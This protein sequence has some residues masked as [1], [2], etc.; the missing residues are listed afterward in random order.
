VDG[1]DADGRSVVVSI[2]ST[3]WCPFG[4]LPSCIQPAQPC[5]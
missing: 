3:G 1:N 4:L 5:L 2:S